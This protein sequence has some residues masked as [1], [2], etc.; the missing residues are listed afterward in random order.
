MNSKPILILSDSPSASTGL[1]R[2]TRDLSTRIHRCLPEFQVGTVRY[3]GSGDRNLPFPQYYAN[4]QDWIPL[5]LPN[6][7]DNFTDG[8]AGI[9]LCIWDAA[10]LGWLGQYDNPELTC[11][12]S[13]WYR[14]MRAKKLIKT[15]IYAPVDAAGPNGKLAYPLKQTLLGFDRVLMY[16][17][18]ANGIV[19]ESGIDNT[20][21]LPHGIDANVWSPRKRDAVRNRL[22]LTDEMFLGIVATNQYRKD[23]TLG[24][25]TAAHLRDQLGKK[26]ALW[27]HTD[28]IERYWSLSTLL[29]DY[30]FIGSKTPVMVTTGD[31]SDNDMAEM[32]SALDVLLGVG[33]GE[34]C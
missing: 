31:L 14:K 12:I 9:L 16:S 23:W 25:R 32:Y 13:D 10:R 26:I 2:I 17:K 24:I 20:E 29:K 22:K 33:R 18:W 4:V 15:W 1:A 30:G 27:L 21:Y 8:E 6:I 3:G 34:G 7:W 28:A 5:D 19:R 11:R